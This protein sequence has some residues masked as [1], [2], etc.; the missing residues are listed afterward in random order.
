MPDG[1]KGAVA[2]DGGT[3]DLLTVSHLTT[4]YRAGN[5][6]KVVVNDVSFTIAPGERVGL[7]GESGS[8]KTTIASSILRI[9]PS[10]ASIDSGSITLGHTDML[11][12]PDTRLRAV[13]SVEISRIPQDPLASLNPVITIGKQL[14]AVVRAHHRVSREEL[15]RKVIDALRAVGIGDAANKLSA[16]PHELSGGMRQRVLI[17]M[18]LINEPNLLVADEPT[19]A[20][21]V[22]VQAQV[23]DLITSSVAVGGMALLL[24]SHDIGVVSELCDR[25]LVMFDGRIVEEG[26]VADVLARPAHPYTRALLESVHG[27]SLDAAAETQTV[28]VDRRVDSRSCRYIARCPLAME[29]CRTEPELS[30]HDGGWLTRC[31][32]ADRVENTTE[33]IGR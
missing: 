6:R 13:R 28:D 25:V 1:S 23:I 9:L 32:A 22:T 2:T 11:A 19:T 29:K 3:P 24:I 17:A 18:A 10:S 30:M 8:G 12:A 26:D 27:V 20:L 14:S 15:D 33:L 5:D 21:D 4:S 16:Y 7:V 31:H